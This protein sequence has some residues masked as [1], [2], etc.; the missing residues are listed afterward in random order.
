MFR[1]SEL[2][3]AVSYWWVLFHEL[4]DVMS[5]KILMI[6]TGAGEKN[7]DIKEVLLS[8]ASNFVITITIPKV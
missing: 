6:V 1:M 5:M 4:S 2:I 8:H 3:G 7:Q